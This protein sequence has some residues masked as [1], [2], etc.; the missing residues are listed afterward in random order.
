MNRQEVL[1]LLTA[2]KEEM[3]RLFGV[4]HLALFGS[5]ARGDTR[6][7][8]DVDLLVEFDGS[9][10]VKGY[11]GVLDYLEQLLGVRVDLATH[12]MIKPWLWAH[13]KKD[14]LHVA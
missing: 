4:K 10:T 1:D 8:S 13:I 9:T 11:F 12:A 3:I 6:P 7:D 14:L 2:H 5:T